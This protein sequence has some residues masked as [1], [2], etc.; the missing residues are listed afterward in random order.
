MLVKFTKLRFF[1]VFIVM[2]AFT[3]AALGNGKYKNGLPENLGIV[4]GKNANTVAY[5]NG[6]DKYISN[7]PNYIW[8]N[9]KQIYT[10]MKWQCV[11]FARRWLIEN[12]S[13]SF[14]DVDYAVN[15]PKLEYGVNMND[16]G[17]EPVNATYY[18]QN[19]NDKPKVGD[20]LIY[21]TMHTE[22]TGHVAVV[23]D[24]K[25][26]EIFVAEQNYINGRWPQSS[27]SRKI[28]LKVT[29][30][31]NLYSIDDYGIMGWVRFG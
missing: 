30:D 1:L 29:Q 12:K 27:Y 23:V 28:E 25:E 18:L 14:P 24:V 22:I 13:I 11:E 21:S 3:M 6:D 20:L 9:E 17:I 8:V 26:N 4:E 16:N 15:I 31:E 2:H 10:G 5:S 7:E 19:S